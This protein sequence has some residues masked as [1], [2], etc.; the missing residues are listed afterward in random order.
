MINFLK[1]I[2]SIFFIFIFLTNTAFSNEYMNARDG[3]QM[4]KNSWPTILD[5]QR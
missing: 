4:D 1:K 2:F 3:V 5:V